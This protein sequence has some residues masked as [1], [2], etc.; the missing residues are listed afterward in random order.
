LS[1]NHTQGSGTAGDN[2]LS[3]HRHEREGRSPGPYTFN[4]TGALPASNTSSAR[5]YPGSFDFE[6]ML[7]SLHDLFERDRQVASQQDSKRCGICYLYFSIGDL[8]YREEEGFYICSA[9]E[10]SL[11]KQTLPMI[12]RQQK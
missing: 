2:N 7:V 8:H 1:N 11:G 5:S 12:R 3:G 4:G 6:E 10:R 9:C